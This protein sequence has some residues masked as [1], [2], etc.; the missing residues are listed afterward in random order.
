MR[1]LPRFSQALFLPLSSVCLVALMS[2]A[3]APKR[4]IS[5]VEGVGGYAVVDQETGTS[6]GRIF[7]PVTDSAGSAIC[8]A[9]IVPAFGGGVP[10]IFTCQRIT[11]NIV[12]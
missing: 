5:P 8:S 3:C 10:P 6:R 9:D 2:T 11:V 12:P 7:F 1:A 4:A